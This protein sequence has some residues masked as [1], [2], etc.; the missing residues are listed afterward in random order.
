MDKELM[1]QLLEINEEL[2]RITYK[3]NTQEILI[4]EYL[5]RDKLISKSTNEYIKDLSTTKELEEYFKEVYKE[6]NDDTKF[7]TWI[8]PTIQGTI[9][10]DNTIIIG[11]PNAFNYHI[12]LQ[13]YTEVLK[14]NNKYKICLKSLNTNEEKII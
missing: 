9:I 2:K 13:N 8:K 14:K 1:E 12:I 4:R 7:G 6:V 10:K 11:C 5:V 3:L